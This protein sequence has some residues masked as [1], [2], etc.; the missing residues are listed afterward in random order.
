M[1]ID[2]QSDIALRIATLAPPGRWT[3]EA[4][5]ESVGVPANHVAKVV[6]RLRL[7]GH[8]TTFPGKNGGFEFVAASMNLSVGELL[9]QFEG[10]AETVNCNQ[11]PCPLASRACLLRQRLH[12]AQ[13]AFFADLDDLTIADLRLHETNQQP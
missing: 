2:R 1:K 8:I 12:R 3:V 7:L 10:E 9:R 11:P 5:A 13:A 4:A 6:R